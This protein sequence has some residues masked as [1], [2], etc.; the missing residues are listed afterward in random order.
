MIDRKNFIDHDMENGKNMCNILKIMAGQ[1][2]DYRTGCLLDYPYFNKP[3]MIAISLSKQQA[4]DADPK[5]IQL[6]KFSG[7]L[8]RDESTTMFFII[9]EAKESSLDFS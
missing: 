3:K 2:D 8:D 5:A 7:N 6:M 1:G 4:V 9:E